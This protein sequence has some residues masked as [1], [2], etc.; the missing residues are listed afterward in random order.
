MGNGKLTAGEQ[1]AHFALWALYKSPLLIGADLR[2]L[3]PDS[4]AILKA[5]ARWALEAGCWC[6]TCLTGCWCRTCLAGCWLRWR[7]G[8]RF[9]R[10]RQAHPSPCLPACLPCPTTLTTLQEVIAINQDDLGVPGEL[11]YV[12]GQT[13][14]S[15][16]SYWGCCWGR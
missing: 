16:A 6:R 11:V 12:S 15:S 8:A 7:R 3:S 5:E 1:R 13:R 10:A 4:L 14:V 9:R 2:R